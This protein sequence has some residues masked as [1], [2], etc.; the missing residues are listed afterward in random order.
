MADTCFLSLLP[1]CNCAICSQHV[2]R[3][4]GLRVGCSS[5]YASTVQDC[6][7]AMLFSF[8]KTKILSRIVCTPIHLGRFLFNWNYESFLHSKVRPGDICTSYP[9]IHVQNWNH[10]ALGNMKYTHAGWDMQM[11]SKRLSQTTY[12]GLFVRHK[13]FDCL[14]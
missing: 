3:K 6:F 5:K 2:P 9:R 10:S 12:S 8:E 13:R 14:L 11:Q 4:V 7:V 1:T